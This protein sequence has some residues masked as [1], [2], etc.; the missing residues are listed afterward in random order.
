M[1]MT[2]HRYASDPL[3]SNY[4]CEWNVQAALKIR[5]RPYALRKYA[6]YRAEAFATDTRKLWFELDYSI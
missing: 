1:I 6:D 5:K 3:S 2:Y 4:G